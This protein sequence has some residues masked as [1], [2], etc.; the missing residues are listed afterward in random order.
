MKLMVSL[1]SVRA[2]LALI[3]FSGCGIVFVMLVGQSLG[4]LFG[5]Q[6]EKAWGWAIPNIAPTLSLMISVFAA[7]ALI[8]SD[9]VDKMKVR[10]T[11]SRLASGLSVFYLINVAIV[12]IAAPFTA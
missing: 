4:G 5:D 7:Y 6:L 2:R 10:Q 1:E 3:W 11:F 8:P 12:I 9:E